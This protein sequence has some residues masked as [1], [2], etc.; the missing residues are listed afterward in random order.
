M[1]EA[2]VGR[3]VLHI[4]SAVWS[5]NLYRQLTDTSQL[6]P[7]RTLLADVMTYYGKRKSSPLLPVL[8]AV[9]MLCCSSL[10]VLVLSSSSFMKV[11]ETC[12][13]C[14]PFVALKARSHELESRLRTM[15][16][17]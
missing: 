13:N 17:K 9:A 4:L 11:N 15:E 7:C 14:G 3:Q 5:I 2:V 10:R 8:A 16:I 6:T 1:R 12:N